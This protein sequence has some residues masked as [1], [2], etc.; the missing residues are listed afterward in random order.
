MKKNEAE[1]TITES[2][3]TAVTAIEG[4]TEAVTPTP[5]PIPEFVVVKK[6]DMKGK[7]KHYRFFTLDAVGAV[8]SVK[9]VGE[10]V[11]EGSMVPVS[12]IVSVAPASEIQLARF[13]GKTG[14]SP[15]LSLLAGVAVAV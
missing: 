5:A 1:S 9:A 14:K 3:V 12:A 6:V 2:E 10:C 11:P 4:S 13:R 7:G 15:D 8:L